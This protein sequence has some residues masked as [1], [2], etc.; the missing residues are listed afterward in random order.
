MTEQERR[1]AE[2][3]IQL[4]FELVEDGIAVTRERLRRE[5]PDVSPA[6]IERRIEAWLASRTQAPL[7]DAEGRPM[8]WPRE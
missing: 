3:R 8:R 1:E 4:V 2:S 5:L 6:E 7:G